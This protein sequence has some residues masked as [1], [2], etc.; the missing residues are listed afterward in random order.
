M[1]NEIKIG[2]FDNVSYSWT[3]AGVIDPYDPPKS[4]MTHFLEKEKKHPRRIL[5]AKTTSS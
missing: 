3:I 4:A 1:N 5:G 2:E